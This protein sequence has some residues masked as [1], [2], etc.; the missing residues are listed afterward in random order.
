MGGLFCSYYVENRIASLRKAII[1]SQLS[2]IKKILASENESYGN[3]FKFVGKML[4]LCSKSKSDQ[5][6]KDSDLLNSQIDKQGNTPLTLSIQSCQPESFKM[7]LLELNADPNK[8]NYL[9]GY[10]P[11][12]TLAST[13]CSASSI[14]TSSSKKS[15]EKKESNTTSASS[16]PIISSSFN[17]GSDLHVAKETMYIH[18]DNNEVCVMS[19]PILRDMIHLL[20]EKG[21]DLNK[22]I[23]MT[24]NGEQK[25]YAN[26]LLLSMYNYNLIAADELLKM[27]CDCN[28][29]EEGKRLSCLDLV[30]Y[31]SSVEM[32]NLLLND[33]MRFVKLKIDIK[34]LNGNNCLHWLALSKKNEDLNIF[35]LIINFLTKRFEHSNFSSPTHS[36]SSNT[37]SLVENGRAFYLN[38]LDEHLKSFLDQQNNEMQTP[39]MLAASRNKQN[40]VK[41]LLDYEASIDLEDKYGKTAINYASKNHACLNLLK[42]FNKI[43]MI[44]IKKNSLKYSKSVPN[45]GNVTNT[46]DSN[47][48]TS[49]TITVEP[50]KNNFAKVI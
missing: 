3:P 45:P 48:K 10:T 26:P 42:S 11:L 43:K 22:S 38:S 19:E 47:T 13:K 44:S 34:S 31:L 21:A 36:E 23:Q 39:L 49:T 6:D 30:C 33:E 15:I 17:N 32:V 5:D 14:R 46:I 24:D 28:Y 37:S 27:G 18:V 12:H 29:Q 1:N 8:A 50:F 7:L 4:S 2:D 25:N 41:Q 16:S 9:T 35:Q 20:A 40:L